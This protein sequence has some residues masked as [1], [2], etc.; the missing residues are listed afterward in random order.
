LQLAIGAAAFQGSASV[1]FFP[2][3]YRATW[4]YFTIQKTRQKKWAE[5]KSAQLFRASIIP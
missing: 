1:E 4:T 3:P 2:P 5:D